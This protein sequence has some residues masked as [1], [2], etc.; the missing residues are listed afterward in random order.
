MTMQQLVRNLTETTASIQSEILLRVWGSATYDTN[1]LDPI[2]LSTNLESNVAWLTE[3]LAE[4]FAPIEAHRG[5]DVV[6]ARADEIG[7]VRAIQGVQIDAV[8]R[9]WRTAGEVITERMIARAEEANSTE[10][11]AAIRHLNMLLAAL[12]DRTVESY[13]SVQ[14]EVTGHYD[15]LS[16]DLV[17][18]IVSGAILDVAEIAQRAEVIHVDPTTPYVAV[19]I[20]IPEQEE[21][22]THLH[23]QRHLLGHLGVRVHRRILLG[24]IDDRPLL[25]VPLAGGSDMLNDLLTSAV[26]SY[27]E[28]PGLVLGVSSTP[29]NLTEA[30]ATAREARVALEVAQRLGR[31]GGIVTYQSVSVEAMLL[32]EPATTALAMRALE[33]LLD[34]PE[35]LQTLRSYLRNGLSARASARELFVHPNTVPHRLAVIQS[36]I[37]R[38]LRDVPAMLDIMLALRFVDLNS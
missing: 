38:D 33:P 32:R 26:T 11:V 23:A 36:L 17:A 13:V 14:R 3:A 15:R 31:V 5:I 30:A 35:L 7:R 9:S 12:T 37:G 1:H 8:I 28:R 27:A 16:T 19:T 10:L 25:L 21:P 6:Y 24:S 20:G 4:P 29:G 34:R 2:D 22:A 18:Q